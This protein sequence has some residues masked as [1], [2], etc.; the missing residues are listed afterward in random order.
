MRESRW[1]GY[2]PTHSPRQL[3]SRPIFD[4]GQIMK[5]LSALLGQY[6]G[7]IFLFNFTVSCI[8][9]AV[10][11]RA[12]AVF[13]WLPAI[14][15]NG[16]FG[17]Y[18]IANALPGFSARG[19]DAI[20]VVFLFIPLGLGLLSIAIA[21]ATCFFRPKLS[22]LWIG[23]SVLTIAIILLFLPKADEGLGRT[24]IIQVLDESG[25]PIAVQASPFF[26]GKND[27]SIKDGKIFA[28]FPYREGY[29]PIVVHRN[30]GKV[31]NIGLSYIGLRSGGNGY[32]LSESEVVGGVEAVEES[33]MYFSIKPEKWKN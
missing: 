23:A 19:P 18:S 2:A 12:F 16:S 4:V 20:G 26:P 13:F 28:R 3:G 21:I 5:S 22:L 31:A 24:A 25:A 32:L 14:L 7:L 17:I 30:D 15:L 10:R 9:I 29:I 11:K 1:S 27:I 6:F 8:A 33:I